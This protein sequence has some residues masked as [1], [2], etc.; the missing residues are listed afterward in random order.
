VAARVAALDAEEKAL[1]AFTQTAPDYDFTLLKDT[2]LAH[3]SP[4]EI[5]KAA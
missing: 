5:P 4:A 2:R 3:Y 1:S